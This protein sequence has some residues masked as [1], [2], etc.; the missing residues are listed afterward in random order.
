MGQP[1]GWVQVVLG[2]GASLIVAGVTVF[3]GNGTRSPWGWILCLWG[4]LICAAGLMSHFDV[5]ATAGR[6]HRLLVVSLTALVTGVL[7]GGSALLLTGSPGSSDSPFAWN[8]HEPNAYF[9]GATGGVGDRTWIK[10]FQATA[11]N[12]SGRSF[13]RISGYVRS[14]ITNN[15]FPL[16]LNI[17]RRL[18]PP[19]ETHGIPLGATFSIGVP[20]PDEFPNPQPPNQTG[21]SAERF[22]VDFGRFTFVFE[23]DGEVYTRQFSAEEI[24][25]QLTRFRRA[26]HREVEPRVTTRPPSPVKWDLTGI[27]T[28]GTYRGD[29][30]VRFSG[31][32]INGRNITNEA[33]TRMSG[34]IRSNITS[35]TLPIY[36]TADGKR[37][38]P[39]QTH[40]IPP[41]A[42][43]EVGA[44]FGPDSYD[45]VTQM[46]DEPTLLQRFG[47][48]TF[49]VELATVS[50]VKWS[51]RDRHGATWCSCA[52][53]R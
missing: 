50:R 47:D 44:V 33:I 34:F 31:F 4:T 3:V 23:Y 41:H 28:M 6:E 39:D 20:F 40:G 22:L 29:N 11:R 10:S 15:T 53:W 2:I 19:E 8:F 12:T 16:S 5:W 49:V 13:R 46:L 17:E 7:G 32:M 36:V 30:T 48:C 38:S 35:K 25:D 24:E 51:V 14:D 37:L 1:S 18:V 26:T 42:A 45:D 9:L 21:I 43:A 27:F 52:S